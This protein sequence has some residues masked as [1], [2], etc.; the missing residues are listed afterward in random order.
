M[1]DGENG[2]DPALSHMRISIRDIPGL[3]SR[4]GL[5]LYPTL[6]SQTGSSFLV[7]GHAGSCVRIVSGLLPMLDSRWLSWLVSAHH[8]GTGALGVYVERKNLLAQTLPNGTSLIV[9]ER[10]TRMRKVCINPTCDN[11]IPMLHQ[12]ACQHVRR[13][14]S[15]QRPL[16]LLENQ[17]RRSTDAS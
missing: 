10:C 5:S 8:S 12:I 13:S 3:V 11:T 6:P 9:N 4:R 17:R 7:S 16:L 1:E 2:V 14:E 15:F